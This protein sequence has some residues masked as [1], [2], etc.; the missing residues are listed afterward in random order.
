MAF[1]DAIDEH[2]AS[3]VAEQIAAFKLNGTDID[4]VWTVLTCQE[5]MAGQITWGLI[6]DKIEDSYR[7]MNLLPPR[8][9][10]NPLIIR[11]D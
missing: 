5:P 7:E 1:A 2:V 10:K 6:S 3:I 4:Q 9:N 8:K 11:K